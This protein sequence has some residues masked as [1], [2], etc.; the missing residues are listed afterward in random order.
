M[1]L[2]L[3]VRHLTIAVVASHCHVRALPQVL[4]QGAAPS[5]QRRLLHHRSWACSQ[6]M[7]LERTRYASVR[8]FLDHMLDEIHVFKIAFL[9]VLVCRTL[10]A[11]ELEII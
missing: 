6:R 3:G 2:S 9:L 4:F 1:V 7:T 11:L 5:K 10:F 8:A